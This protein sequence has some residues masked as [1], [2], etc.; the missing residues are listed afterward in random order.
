MRL[1][2]SHFNSMT[3][4]YLGLGAGETDCQI[5]CFDRASQRATV[6]DVDDR[7]VVWAICC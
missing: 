7:M 1:P 5:K 3:L 2:S 6:V 4:Y